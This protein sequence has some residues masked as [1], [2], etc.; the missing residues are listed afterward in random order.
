M[1]L[2]ILTF[3]LTNGSYYF[4]Y[5]SQVTIEVQMA[6]AIAVFWTCV[7]IISIVTSPIINAIGIVGT[8]SLFGVISLIGGIY[9]ILQM[10]QTD[11]LTTGA[12]K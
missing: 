9:F 5:V 10:K 6:F 4:P 2:L 3:Q 7:L 8:F 1:V 11:G 12:A